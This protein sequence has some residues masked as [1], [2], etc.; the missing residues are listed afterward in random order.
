MAIV[1]AILIPITAILFSLV[2]VKAYTLGLKHSYELKHDIKPTTEPNTIVQ[3][4]NKVQDKK[5]A[6]EER[7]IYHEYLYGEEEK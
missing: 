3:L 7:D 6:D 5:S 4:I 2:V 1:L